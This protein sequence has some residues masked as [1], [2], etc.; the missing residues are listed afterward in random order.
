[1][2]N[3]NL[4]KNW[5]TGFSIKAKMI[6]IFMLCVQL[7]FGQS[8]TLGKLDLFH[9]ASFS[10][11]ARTL[12]LPPNLGVQ[13][14]D[15]HIKVGGVSF[16]SVAQPAINLKG[17]TVSIDYINNQ[18]VVKVGGQ[19]FY[20]ELPNWQLIP[21]AKFA[22]TSDKAI[23]TIY[24]KQIDKNGP[25]CRFQSAFLDNLLGLRLFQSDLLFH[26]NDMW[27][28]PKDKSG[29]YIF[30][31]SEKEKVPPTSIT[32]QLIEIHNALVS[33]F[34]KGTF[35]SYIF[36]DYG[37]SVTFEITDNKFVIK[38]LPYYLFT[39]YDKDW[40]YFENQTR[41]HIQEL[42]QNSNTYVALK[43]DNP[44]NNDL[45]KQIKS[46]LN[47][48]SGN[49]G[50]YIKSL[51]DKH[52]SAKD[53]MQYVNRRKIFVD[54]MREEINK[55]NDRELLSLSDFCNVE[56]SASLYVYLKVLN[57]NYPAKYT[58][59]MKM[60]DTYYNENTT[61]D[62]CYLLKN[63]YTGA[64]KFTFQTELTGLFKNNWHIIYAYNPVVYDASLNTMRWAA[65]FRYVKNTNPNNWNAFMKKAPAI[66]YDAPDV[67]TPTSFK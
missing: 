48:P 9:D 12:A 52:W 20:P 63:Y 35:Q 27:E 5:K 49:K 15:F 45:Y 53:S 44:I 26:V 40:Q 18:F 65:F 2:N 11:M 22:N 23:F 62:L 61:G 17:Q 8:Y 34:K 28:I 37:E 59:L 38:G 1:M 58:N 55:S 19:T 25:Q 6:A 67:K 16:E 51:L 54:K 24:G 41:N 7:A 30:A 57:H 64:I 4:I 56:N 13:D 39:K 42:E 43:I 32:N 47:A 46:R 3:L 36:T 50:E 33:L 14:Y 31:N 29:K 66:R 60:C 21:I 10:Q